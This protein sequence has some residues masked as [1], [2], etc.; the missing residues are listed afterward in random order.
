MYFSLHKLSQTKSYCSHLRNINK[1]AYIEICTLS[2]ELYF[3]M[4]L[5]FQMDEKLFIIC[6]KVHPMSTFI[7]KHSLC[8]TSTVGDKCV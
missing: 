4:Q 5:C 8:F 6:N 2:K 3:I 1:Q 7:L